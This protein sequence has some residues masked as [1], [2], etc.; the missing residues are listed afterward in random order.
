MST[1]EQSLETLVATLESQ[2]K[3]RKDYIVNPKRVH[4][5][6]GKLNIEVKKSEG[7][8]YV[9]NEVAH[10]QIA[11]KLKI[12][13]DY[14]RKMRFSQKDL[15][16]VNVNTWMH[17]LEDRGL[18]ARTFDYG[19]PEENLVRAILSDS[20]GICDN[21]DVMLAALDVIRQSKIDVNIEECT[22]TDK[23]MYLHITAP[24]IE[25]QA[26][27]MLK[28]Y[29]REKGDAVGYGIIAGIVISNS[30]VGF[31]AFNI[32]PRAVIIRCNNGLIMPSDNFRKIHL[33]AKLGEGSIQ[34]SE[35][36]V[37]KNM[38]LIL[39]QTRDSL[40]QFL[41]EGYLSNMVQKIEAASKQ[42]LEKPLDTVQNVV[43]EIGKSIS[44]DE[45]RKKSILDHFIKGGDTNASGVF[46][47]L[48]MEAQFMPADD[49]FA[50][51]STA[52][53]MLPKI[54]SFDKEFKVGR[55]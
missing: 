45:A 23:R 25:I 36:T 44:M 12:P 48:T 9:P 21:L 20:Y 40:R 31:G 47:A 26:K 52:F 10:M 38:D 39:A 11:Q 41:S 5:I 51:E 54:K 42:T 19:N 18:M 3:A 35:D 50:M 14:Y 27:E 28:N 17:Q 33:G 2:R 32:S 6:G 55:N 37:A 16:D 53:T 7:G 13:A 24:K 1:Q 8:I 30:E 22:V 46:H 15:L 49:R 4:M 34:W 29:L 43:K